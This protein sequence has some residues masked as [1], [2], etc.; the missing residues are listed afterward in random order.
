M[1]DKGNRISQVVENRQHIIKH[2]RGKMF[3]SESLKIVALICMLID[4][5]G[6]TLFPQCDI[7]RSIGRVSFPLYAFLLAQGCKHTHSMERY[8]LGLGIF[9]LISEIP[10]DLAFGNSINFLDQTNIFYTLFLSVHSAAPSG[11]WCGGQRQLSAANGSLV[12]GGCSGF[13]HHGV[14]L[15]CTLQD[16]V[17][18]D[19]VIQNHG[20]PACRFPLRADNGAEINLA[21]LLQNFK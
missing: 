14:V 10:Y 17:G 4:H 20:A 7:L 11:S 2:C 5:A 3:T 8:L 6:A 1:S 12:L 15:G 16:S 9:A 21:S 19:L 13:N 18:G